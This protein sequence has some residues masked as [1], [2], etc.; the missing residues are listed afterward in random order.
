[1]SCNSTKLMHS[2]HNHNIIFT[3]PVIKS[4]LHRLSEIANWTQK[5]LVVLEYAVA[6]WHT[7]LNVD[8]MCLMSLNSKKA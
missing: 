7:G 2:S 8:Q 6:V 4:Q 1:M 3:L 5:I